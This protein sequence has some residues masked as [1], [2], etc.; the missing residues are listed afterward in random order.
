MSNKIIVHIGLHKTA[1]TSLQYDVFPRFQE[2]SYIGRVRGNLSNQSEIYKQICKYCFNEEYDL[3]AQRRIREI[4]EA[5]LQSTSILLSEE[6]FT[7]DYSGYYGFQ[8]CSWQTK[9]ERLSYLLHGI[10]HKIILTIR[11]PVQGLFSQYCEFNA[12]G[13]ESRFN[14]FEE[15]AFFSNDSK[16][17]KY[18]DLDHICVGLFS[19]VAYI[20]FKDLI[21]DDGLNILTHEI[22]ETVIANL[23]HYNKKTKNDGGVLVDKPSWMLDLLSSL[24]PDSLRTFLGKVNSFERLKAWLVKVFTKRVLVTEPSL[25]LRNKLYE[26]FD[27]SFTF[28]KEIVKTGSK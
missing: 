7:S 3:S 17:Y 26:E 16:V 18:K 2:F 4:L 13:I 21:S 12:V 23:G 6:W 8:G 14:N 9:L 22:G 25:E 5:Q 27:D 24:V 20:S 11:E 19:N 1:T 15:Y 28:Y 10:D